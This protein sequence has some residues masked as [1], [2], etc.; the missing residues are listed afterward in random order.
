[1]SKAIESRPLFVAIVCSLLLL[2]VSERANASYDHD[3][4]PLNTAIGGL[5]RVEGIGSVAIGRGTRAGDR[6]SIAIG[7]GTDID[8]LN[9]GI[10]NY[11]TIPAV[12]DNG[13]IAIGSGARSLTAGDVNFGSRKLSGLLDGVQDDEAVT[14]RQLNA[15]RAGLSASGSGVTASSADI[16]S[17]VAAQGERTLNDAKAYSDQSVSQ[18][19]TT[20]N[21]Y[22]NEQKTAAVAESKAY[23]DAARSQWENQ[24]QQDKAD[25]IAAANTYT[26]KAKEEVK[27]YTDKTKEEVKTYTDKT[28]EEV[29]T[30]VNS[31]RDE[32]KAY[33]HEQKDVAI[34]TANA[35]TDKVQEDTL[36]Q[37]RSYVKL[38]SAKAFESAREYADQSAINML[39][40]A[41]DYA[42]QRSQQAQELAI[43]KANR[44]TDQ[45]VGQLQSQMKRLR[46]RANA[47]I[48]GAM[49]MT[50]L[51]PP[52]AG[53]NTSFG[54]AMAGYR[55]QF[56]IASGA[57]FRLAENRH[58][59]LNSSWD[60]SGGI[61]IA[62][63]FN[64]AW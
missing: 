19:V 43:S 14:V 28:R 55:N 54:M 16:A 24:A 3:R 10:A 39:T 1:M 31:A 41:K 42:N 47:G 21:A 38:E 20:A 23:T 49:A 57:T 2:G 22:T 6:S 29:K 45:R 5:S 30:F 25:A 33:S 48:S 36:T 35:Y 44:Y 40:S 18:A 63:G 56:A 11:H 62:A 37:A 26:D 12:A 59:K 32:V 46:N 51:T 15:A 52:P 58:I 27:T 4:P 60:S 17:A 9:T 53:T 8:G 64:M 13:G 34:K 50:A 61:G 7:G